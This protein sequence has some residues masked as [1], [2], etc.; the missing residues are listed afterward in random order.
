[1]NLD[2]KV[3]WHKSKEVRVPKVSVIIPVYN[4]EQYISK[5]LDCVINQ[6][7]EDIEVIC[8]ND[9][10]T[11]GSLKI[12]QEYASKD[13][14]IKLIDLHQNVGSGE[15][16]NKG[17]EIVKGEYIGFVDPDD[18]IDLNF[19]EELYKKASETN[20]DI[21][22]GELIIIDFD[23]IAKESKVKNEQIKKSKFYF[24]FD[25]T[26]AIY[27]TSVIIKNNIIF[28]S[29]LIVGE[30]VVFLH[31]VILKSKI[32]EL[33]NNTKYYY[34]R[35]ENSLN[36]Y[37]YDDKRV[38]SAIKTIEYKA[39]NYNNSYDIDILHDEYLEQY[40]L[41]MFVL[42]GY[43]IN[44]TPK[45]SLKLEC[46][47]KFIE[48]FNNC[49]IKKELENVFV[50]KN[51]SEVLDLIK[52]NKIEYLLEICK[53]YKTLTNYCTIVKLRNNVK[54]D[55]KNVKCISNYTYI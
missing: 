22:K 23:G 49:K 51:Q 26:S 28:P 19:Y 8:I 9:C 21:V 20:A 47:K 27:K 42:V 5:C 35:R 38:L 53:K 50:Q 13:N 25:Y 11:D 12:L 6:T 14:R 39:N 1:M 2:I 43:T 4:V 33:I 37:I 45:K 17:L 52:N 40:Y 32:I 29:A 48:L 30:D 10:S 54:T 46:I 24:Y 15:A 7:L 34:I 18:C 36:T 31:K 55:M 3:I 16:K 41:N 44:L